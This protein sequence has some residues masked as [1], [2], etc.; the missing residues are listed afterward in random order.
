MRIERVRLSA[1]FLEKL[2]FPDFFARIS[3]L[4]I[5]TAFNYDKNHFFSLARIIFKPGHEQDWNHIMEQ[6]LH[7]T[8]VQEL[9]RQELSIDCIIQSTSAGGFFPLPV[10]EQGSWAIMPPVTMTPES[11]TFNLLAEE[12][13]LPKIHDIITSF[14]NEIT[15][16]ALDDLRHE[17]RD[18][19]MLM[20][21]FTDRQ[22]E[23][24]SYAVHN[25]FYKSPKRI[26]AEQIAAHFDIT[27]S[28]VTEHLRKARQIALEYFFG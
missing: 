24:T 18:N 8:F 21:A 12:T 6:D 11:I 22:R 27:V 17:L 1:D 4:E 25:G 5:T 9:A 23:I 19:R 15:I 3:F 16:L 10:M 26:T 20:P 2:G 7:V 14:G 28:A 13:M